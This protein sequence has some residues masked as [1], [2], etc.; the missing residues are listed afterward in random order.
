MDAVPSSPNLFDYQPLDQRFDEMLDAQGQLRPSWKTLANSV[1]QLGAVELQRR[2]EEAAFQ[3]E[4]DGITFNPYDLAEGASRPWSLDPIPLLIQQTEW[5]E[6]SPRL[7]QRAILMDLI[8]RDLFGPQRLLKEKLLPPDFLFAHP[9]FHVSYMQLSDP[10]VRQLQLYAAELA[11]SPDGNWWVT[12]DRTRAPFGLGY[13]LENRIITSRLLPEAFRE[14]H[15]QRLANFFMTLQKCLATM[16]PD[17]NANP[18]V[19]LWTKG[20]K[21]R[22][23]FEDAYL[24]R[25][26]G[27]TLVQADDL[28]VRQ[29]RVMLKTL[30]GLVPVDVIF[31]RLDDD[32]CDPVELDGRSTSGVSNLLDVVRNGKVAVANRLGSRLVESPLLHP[33]LPQIAQFLLGEPLKLPTVAS[34]WCGNPEHLAMVTD[35][36]ENLLFRKSFRVDNAAPDIPSQ[37]TNKQREAFFAQVHANPQQYVAQQ[38]VKHSTV[39]VW[40]DTAVSPWPLAVRAFLVSNEDGYQTLDSGLARVAKNPEALEYAP[41][42]GERSQDVWITG[43]QAPPKGSLLPSK[44]TPIK[45]RRG[46]SELPSRVADSLFWLGR[47]AERAEFLL[48]TVRMTLN[49]LEDERADLLEQSRILRALAEL[50]QIPPDLVV[51]GI[52]ETLPRIEVSLP[53]ILLSPEMSM[54]FRASVDQVIRL[55]SSV[56][57]RISLDAWRILHNLEQVCEREARMPTLSLPRTLS[58]VDMLVTKLLAF[59]GLITESMTRTLA[60]RFLE[61]GRRLERGWQTAKFLQ[62]MLQPHESDDSASLDVALEVMDSLM[63]YRSRYLSTLHPVAVCDLLITDQTNPRSIAFQLY[64]LQQHVDQL[65]RDPGQVG[66]TTVQRMASSLMH[67][68]VM[69]DPAQLMKPQETGQRK[70]LQVLLEQ[71]QREL[72]KLSDVVSSHFLIHAGLQRHFANAEH[73]G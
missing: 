17:K 65:P 23:Y 39:P 16:A 45:L 69:A 3:I 12:G 2:N 46:G 63:T 57:D 59:S 72:P 21:S 4:N 36:Y 66:P 9:A 42:S 24:A 6:L 7:E 31:R 8:I 27:Y 35:N 64:N 60:W 28:A 11:R 19:V 68:V 53:Q 61:L 20:P 62:V 37:M 33:F 22:A 40:D 51:P 34:W 15:T 25:Y 50:G 14:C 32:L 5:A 48:R 52:K 73:L 58:L 1:N 43:A 13:V 49:L 41:T 10:N 30:G 47:N 44:L 29:D 70:A 56:R 38:R 26:L 18:H 54:G 55:G 71:V 67:S